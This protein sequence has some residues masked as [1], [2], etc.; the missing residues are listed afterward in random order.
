MD[1]LFGNCFSRPGKIN[2]GKFKLEPVGKA[3]NKSL[4][5]EEQNSIVELLI[6]RQKKIVKCVIIG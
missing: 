1:I 3:Y 4:R 2:V 6:A 5:N